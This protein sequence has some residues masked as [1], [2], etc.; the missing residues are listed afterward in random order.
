MDTSDECTPVEDNFPYQHLFVIFTHILW[1][2]DISNY[3]A[4]VKVPEHLPY[5]EQRRII[6]HSAR[7]SCREHAHN[8]ICT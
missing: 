3:L 7:Y 4:I 1:Y 2:V 6:H 5:R 8:T